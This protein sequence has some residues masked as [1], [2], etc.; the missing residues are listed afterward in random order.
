MSTLLNVDRVERAN[1]G[2]EHLASHKCSTTTLRE[3]VSLIRVAQNAQIHQVLRI[4][5]DTAPAL[6]DLENA[7]SRVI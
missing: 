7:G 2:L 1:V 5:A 3:N 4:T 6:D